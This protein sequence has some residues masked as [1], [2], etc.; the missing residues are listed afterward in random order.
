VP[1][2]ALHGLPFHAFGE[3]HD[4]VL[5]RWELAYLPSAAFRLIGPI[6]RTGPIQAQPFP[7]TAER[8]RSSQTSP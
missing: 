5:D 4:A 8:E 1:H 3:A 7:R 6:S 2:G